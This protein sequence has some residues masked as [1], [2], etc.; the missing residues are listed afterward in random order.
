MNQP[1]S[2]LP[3]MGSSSSKESRSGRSLNELT[4]QEILFSPVDDILI[5]RNSDASTGLSAG[6]SGMNWGGKLGLEKSRRAKKR[7]KRVLD[8]P[9][10]KD[11]STRIG[12]DQVDGFVA[13]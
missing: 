2:N 7:T 3:V 11:A 6:A 13:S 1:K 10:F 5:P 4:W 12:L 8:E 9:V